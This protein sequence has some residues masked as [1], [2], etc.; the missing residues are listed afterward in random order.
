[1]LQFRVKYMKKKK[2]NSRKR[3]W[4]RH[5]RTFLKSKLGMSKRQTLFESS[6]CRKT[7]FREIL[8]W[9]YKHWSRPQMHNSAF[10]NPGKVDT[11]R[12][13]CKHAE[14][15]TPFSPLG[16]LAKRLT[17]I[18][19][20]LLAGSSFSSKENSFWKLRGA[21]KIP[22]VIETGLSCGKPDCLWTDSVSWTEWIWISS[23][24]HPNHKGLLLEHQHLF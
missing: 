23:S 16:R 1:M 12:V 7:G 17:S 6:A 8:T 5:G 3:T 15:K 22:T 20:V 2:N 9:I 4:S 13:I 14:T 11:V 18:S 21:G 19:L 10:Y 24:N